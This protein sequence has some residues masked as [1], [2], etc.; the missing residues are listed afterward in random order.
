MRV[1]VRVKVRVR[2]RVKVS[3]RVRVRVR[4]RLGIGLGLAT[5]VRRA[6]SPSFSVR[7]ERPSS[8][9]PPSCSREA[10]FFEV[11]MSPPPV[12]S[13]KSTNLGLPSLVV[14]RPAAAR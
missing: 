3:V 10:A 13:R 12:Q 11:S 14:S 1:R 2:I 4:V 5:L 7:P 6:Q 9:R 8:T